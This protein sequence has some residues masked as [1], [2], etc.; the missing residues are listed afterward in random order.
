MHFKD[1]TRIVYEPQGSGSPRSVATGAFDDGT[2]M[3]CS[4]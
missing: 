3:L 4:R 1:G 2:E